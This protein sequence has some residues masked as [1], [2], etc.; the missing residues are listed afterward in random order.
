M[1]IAKT[2]IIYFIA[3][4]V[5][6]IFGLGTDIVISRNLGAAGRGSYYLVVTTYTMAAGVAILAMN[7]ASTY[8]LAKSKATV[9]EVHGVVIAYVFLAAA[10]AGMLLLFLSRLFPGA[11]GLQLKSNLYIIIIMLTIE[12]YR[13]CWF[14]M[15]IGMSRVVTL[16][17]INLTLSCLSL[18]T[19]IALLNIFH[20]GLRG[21]FWG[22]LFNSLMSL[23][24]MVWIV[25]KVSKG[26][27]LARFGLLKEML[28]YG[29]IAH[30]GNAAVQ[31]Y[32][33]IGIYF[34]TITRGMAE[35]GN[36]TLSLTMAE[37]Q[38]LALNAVNV[39]ANYEIIGNDRKSSELLMATILRFSVVL[40]V[41][42]C[43]LALVCSHWIVRVLYGQHYLHA[44][45]LLMILLPG[46][47][48]LGLASMISNYF[49][50]Q[51]GK[52]Y[53]T[54]II[55]IIFLC[56][57]VPLYY[58]FIKLMGS[59]GAAFV[60]SSVYVFHFLVL[61][62]LFSKM[63]GLSLRKSL[64]INNNDISKIPLSKLLGKFQ[65]YQTRRIP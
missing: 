42:I 28:K 56:I 63:S 36:F 3:Q 15:M 17:I 29:G 23:L 11:L 53:I 51:L 59:I 34:L 57:S 1:A 26:F 16:A 10:I 25:L 7:Y 46:T 47:S 31:L 48:F 37:K 6:L 64:L 49:S 41:I 2:S 9:V 39:A 55:S 30:A 44:V 60:I 61:L 52:P 43:T 5:A 33:R 8:M 22:L 32:Q 24:L 40:L 12:L 58:C 50:G 35:V 62:V 14:G 19:M 38:L 54:S 4:I 20:L 45:S 65:R 27:C 21:A 13:Q 18:I